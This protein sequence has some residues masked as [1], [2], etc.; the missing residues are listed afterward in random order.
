MSIIQIDNK[1]CFISRKVI[2]CDLS[3]SETEESLVPD[4]Y[5]R[6]LV[7]IYLLKS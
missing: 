4:G 7:A 3:I 2:R 6:P 1:S 5:M